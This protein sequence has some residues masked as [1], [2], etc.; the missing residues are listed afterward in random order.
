[1]EVFLVIEAMQSS[2]AIKL[3]FWPSTLV[4]NLFKTTQ[5]AGISSFVVRNFT[6]IEWTDKS[7]HPDTEYSLVDHTSKFLVRYSNPQ[8]SG[9]AVVMRAYKIIYTLYTSSFWNIFEKFDE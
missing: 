3:P 6:N 4:I 5:T 9:A 8:Q 7:R 1:M 2:T